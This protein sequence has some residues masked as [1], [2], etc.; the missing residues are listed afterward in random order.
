M[1]ASGPYLFANENLSTFEEPPW[2]AEAHTNTHTHTDYFLLLNNDMT[3]W[4]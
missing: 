2:R 4:V 3:M 1:T